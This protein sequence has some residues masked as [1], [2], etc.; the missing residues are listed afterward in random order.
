MKIT[1]I[2]A[3]PSRNTFSVLPINK[4]VKFYLRNSNISIDPFARNK[5][6]ATYTNDLNPNTKAEFHM[7]AL[8]YLEMLIAQE[9][10]ADLILFDPPYSLT[11]MKRSYEDFG[12]KISQ[13]ESQ[14]F[15]GDL[16]DAFNKVLL[17]NGIAISFGWNS[18]GM[19][20]KR[21]YKIIEILMV[22]HG[23]A[24]NDTLCVVDQKSTQLE[25]MK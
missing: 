10:K 25:L 14:H 17:P 24:H 12:R 1:R 2:F 6:W 11:Q 13:R 21:G 23:R 22:C 5:R 8:D 4:L 9:V 18:I 7:D 15:Y 3:E 19:G 20:K 16:R